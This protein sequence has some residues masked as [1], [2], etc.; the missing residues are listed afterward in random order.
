MFTALPL[1]TLISCAACNR[2]TARSPITPS[3]KLPTTKNT[4]PLPHILNSNVGLER[5]NGVPVVSIRCRASVDTTFIW[6]SWKQAH[7]TEPWTKKSSIACEEKIGHLSPEGEYTFQIQACK[8]AMDSSIQKPLC[9]HAKVISLTI[10]PASDLQEQA[11]WQARA[12]IDDKLR[13]KAT[14]MFILLQNDSQHFQ[15]DLLAIREKIPKESQGELL[16]QLITLAKSISQE[17]WQDLVAT[18]LV[19]HPQ[20]QKSS[21]TEPNLAGTDNFNEN[22]DK[23]SFQNINPSTVISTILLLVLLQQRLQKIWS[24]P[25]YI[26]ADRELDLQRQKSYT[27]EQIRILEEPEAQSKWPPEVLQAKKA[28]QIKR[29][30]FLRTQEKQWIETKPVE[31]HS[32]FQKKIQ[33]AKYKRA[34]AI[35]ALSGLAIWAVHTVHSEGD[36]SALRKITEASQSINFGLTHNIHQRKWF[37]IVQEIVVLQNQ[38]LSLDEQIHLK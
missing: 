38:A 1:L 18:Y 7:S 8:H 17:Q 19:L 20:H 5:I 21:A 34:F 37:Q 28:E 27:Q 30:E 22:Q 23:K 26:Y 10:P 4:R 25:K 16:N 14:Q 36:T 3:A 13:A 6:I 12:D 32:D 15:S 33:R 31:S 9:S 2:K 11:T 29:L 35:T 24:G